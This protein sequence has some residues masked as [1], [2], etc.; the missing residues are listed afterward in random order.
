MGR[1]LPERW[2]SRQCHACLCVHP[3]TFLGLHE[4]DFPDV[5][6]FFYLLRQP[7]R[8]CD[9]TAVDRRA[10]G[11]T[12]TVPAAYQRYSNGSS[13]D[14]V[15]DASSAFARPAASIHPAKS[16]PPLL[17]TVQP[18][19]ISRTTPVEKSQR[20]SQPAA[21]RPRRDEMIAWP[22]CRPPSSRFLA[23][24]TRRTPG[25]SAS[26]LSVTSHKPTCVTLPGPLT[27]K[28]MTKEPPGLQTVL[29][30]EAGFLGP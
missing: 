28:Y 16:L 11:A 9:P 4:V 8:T 5:P 27:A 18:G 21:A 19:P 20:K 24:A 2:A 26:K 22:A 14:S 13:S 10:V 12:L 15:A 23:Q 7:R 17:Q 1:G 3:N 25:C 6:I 29:T 30:L